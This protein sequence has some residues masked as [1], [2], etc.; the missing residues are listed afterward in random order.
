MRAFRT[1]LKSFVK[2]KFFIIIAAVAVFLT[3]VPSV[4]AVMGRQDLLRGAVNLI[5]TPFKAAAKWCGDSLNGFTEYFTE[6]DRLKEENE[7]LR[8][9]LEEERKKNDGID[10]ALEENEWLRDFLLFANKNPQLSFVDATAVGRDSG[11]L[12]TSFTLNK[13]TLNGISTGMAVMGREGLI[14]YVSEVGLS[15]AKVTTIVS[16]NASVGAV[17]PRSGAYGTIEGGYGFLSD[18]LIKM[19]CPD[20][21][22]DISE[23]DVIYTSGAGSVY[24]Y[25]ISVGRV[26]SAEKDPY[27]RSTVAYVE[28]GID[29]SAIGKVMVVIGFTS[30]GETDE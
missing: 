9:E 26:V 18:G 11:D 15:Y 24:P 19:V 12:I 17:C 1:Q 5:A 3:V 20:E 13:G 4:L 2:S 25:G 8:E 28:P 6:F 22:A 23:G 21:N 14:G 10:I 7:K 30:G 27:S 16:G 29:F